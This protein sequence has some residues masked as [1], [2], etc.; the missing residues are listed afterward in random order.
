MKLDR[1]IVGT[2]EKPRP[3]VLPLEML[4]WEQG[5]KTIHLD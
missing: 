5:M 2:V 3:D 1:E 4:M